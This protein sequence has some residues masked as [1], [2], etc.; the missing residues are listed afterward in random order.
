MGEIGLLG[1]PIEEAESGGLVGLT[2]EGVEELRR[3]E[4]RGESS[5]V[6]GGEADG[7]RRSS[8]CGR[9]GERERWVSYGQG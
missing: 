3:S 5:G 8:R 6:R 9:E 2:A 4:V 7:G 1:G